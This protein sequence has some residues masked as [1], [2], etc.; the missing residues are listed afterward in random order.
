[1]VRRK[2]DR[3]CSCSAMS[4]LIELRVDLG[5]GHLD[6]LDLDPPAGQ[7]LKLLLELLDLGPLAADDHARPRRRQ[8]DRHRVAGPLDLD[9]GDAGEAVL[10]S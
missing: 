3:F 1:M 5:P 8:Q 10:A 6:D 2:L 4:S 9:L 7:V